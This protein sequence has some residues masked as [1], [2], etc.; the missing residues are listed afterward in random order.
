[1][2]LR[3]AL[4]TIQ[5][6][7]SHALGR[8]VHMDYRNRRRRCRK[9]YPRSI[10]LKL[11]HRLKIGIL[12]GKLDISGPNLPGFSAKNSW[13]TIY[14]SARSYESYEPLFANLGATSYF[15]DFCP[16]KSKVSVQK[17][18]FQYHR[19]SNIMGSILIPRST[20]KNNFLLLQTLAR[21]RSKKFLRQIKGCRGTQGKIRNPKMRNL[22]TLVFLPPPPHK[23]F[24][25][26][27]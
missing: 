18:I 10:T 2:L 27:L 22:A 15:T 11:W 20:F 4:L 9:F 17:I 24:T 26:L 8:T 1:M 16:E 14:A 5:G 13:P 21:T 23:H 25:T 6:H 3:S 19:I 12:R 7:R